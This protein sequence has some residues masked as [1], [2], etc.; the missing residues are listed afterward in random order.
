MP[1]R[2]FRICLPHLWVQIKMILQGWEWSALDIWVTGARAHLPHFLSSL[3]FFFLQSQWVLSRE[4]D[5]G[6]QRAAAETPLQ[7]V[8]WEQGSSRG[9][10]L[11]KRW[12]LGG[13]PA[14]ETPPLPSAR[15]R[16]I[17]NRASVF[18]MRPDSRR[19]HQCSQRM[20]GN[21]QQ[22]R[23]GIIHNQNQTTHTS[24]P[25]TGP[26]QGHLTTWAQ[27]KRPSGAVM[28]EKNQQTW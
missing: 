5:A 12:P 15:V 11:T 22:Q 8:K 26:Q 28:R 21:Q 20:T 14:A 18:E 24:S 10:H 23:A 9:G 4:G 1:L 25:I 7:P 17:N 2:C 13:D 27:N 19:P 3:F 6:P 16:L